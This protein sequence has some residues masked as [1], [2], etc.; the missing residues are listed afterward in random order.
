MGDNQTEQG[1]LLSGL[2]GI[3]PL[4]FLAS[5][6]VAVVMRH[7]YSE[8]RMG[9]RSTKDGWKPF[10]DS[11]INNKEKFSNELFNNLRSSEM[12]VFDES[13]K[14]PFEAKKFVQILK[15]FQDSSSIEERRNVDL[16]AGTGTELYPNKDDDF[17]D[18]EFRLV[19]SGDSAGHG[20]PYYAR[21]NIKEITLEQV[22]STLFE[23]WQYSDDKYS[24]RL[25]PIE[26]QRYGQIWN[27]PSKKKKKMLSTMRTANVLAV[28]ALRLFPTVLVGN[29]AHTTGFH[30]YSKKRYFVWPIWTPMITL[31]VIRSLLSSSVIYSSK[32]NEQLMMMGIE[33]VYR[34]MRVQ[35]SKNYANFVGAEPL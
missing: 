1:V 35:Q 15:K 5:V 2:V 21:Q 3:N 27:N 17:Q 25:D 10:V 14:M 4:G 6:G 8:I 7:T 31:D 32:Q 16:L 34:S 19:R 26:D 12:E 11:G 24:L 30:K 33:Q 23:P 22:H 28:E 9:W 20:F 13:D 29:R 18:T